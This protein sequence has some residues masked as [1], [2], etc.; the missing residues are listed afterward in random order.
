MGLRARIFFAIMGW[1]QVIKKLGILGAAFL[2][3]GAGFGFGVYV[4]YS[5]RPSIERVTGLYNK[6]TTKP[7]TVDFAPFWKAWSLLEER[8]VDGDS[9]DQQALVYGAIA[10][11][12]EALG[13]PYTVFFPPKEK[14][15]F[16]SEIKGR[17]EGIGAEIGIRDEVLTVISPLAG[18]P[19]AM[20]GLLAGDKIL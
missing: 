6:E 10:G 7:G 15:L 1:M 5:Q 14:E 2:I 4:G 3:I 19:A 13:D 20:A 17:F 12:V 16:E 11:M 18:S 8:Y 9:I